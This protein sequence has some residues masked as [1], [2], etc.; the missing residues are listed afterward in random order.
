[1]SRT[2]PVELLRAVRVSA[3]TK[4]AE[5]QDFTSPAGA[6][7]RHIDIPEP[8]VVHPVHRAW[9]AECLGQSVEWVERTL[10]EGTLDQPC[11]ARAIAKALCESQGRG[12]ARLGRMGIDPCELVLRRVPL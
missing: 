7:T 6:E 3:N 10:N 5:D 9:V 2:D 12:R 11:G 1:M 4:P 8:G